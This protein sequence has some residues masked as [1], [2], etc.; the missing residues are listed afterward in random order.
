[1]T[2]LF[3]TN[4]FELR[5]NYYQDIEFD[6]IG[7]DTTYQP[8]IIVHTVTASNADLQQVFSPD[9]NSSG[10]FTRYGDVTPLLQSTDDK[11]V[12]GRE[13]DTV[14]L[15]FPANL[16]PVPPGMVRDYFIVASCWF[17]GLGLSYVPF[18]V[19]PLPFQAMTSFP[20]PSNETY[21]YD[22]NHLQYLQM[23]NTRIIN[24]P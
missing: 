10:A 7:V 20:Y 4:N 19:D 13:G 22:N 12:I 21:P 16:P 3:P 14:S 5:I 9:S 11:F 23:Y 8:N 6:S 15:Q 17:K 1:L 18:T 2:G 24:S